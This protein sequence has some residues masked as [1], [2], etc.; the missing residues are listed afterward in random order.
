M[1]I[2]GRVMCVFGVHK[3]DAS[4][5]AKRGSLYQAPC[6]HCGKR[7]QRLVDGGRWSVM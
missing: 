5:V 7:L 2:I 3:R 1:R 6:Q 4:R